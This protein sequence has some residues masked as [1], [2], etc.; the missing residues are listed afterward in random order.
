[1]LF[2]SP[3]HFSKCIMQ[4][5]KLGLR[6]CSSALLVFPVVVRRGTVR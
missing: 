1:M 6:I 3:N 4:R 2:P 5:M